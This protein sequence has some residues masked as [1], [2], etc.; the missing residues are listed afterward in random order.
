MEGVTTT[1]LLARSVN[2]GEADR[3]CTLLTEEL[4][5]VSALAKAARK[6]RKR[7]GGALSLFVVGRAVLKRPRRG[8]LLLLERFE[9]VE[10]LSGAV[11]SDVIK[12]AHGSYILEV[13]RELWPAEQ[14]EPEGFELVR[15]TLRALA[16]SPPAPP[17][18][19]CF[20]LG[21]LEVV[22]LAP[23]L[24][25]CVSCG[26]DDPDDGWFDVAHGGA[27]C[28]SCGPRGWPLAAD[29]RRMLLRL[30]TLAVGEAA[31]VIQPKAVARKTRDIMLATMRHHI[32]KDLQSLQF[33]VQM[34]GQ[35]PPSKS[36]E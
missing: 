35:R 26:L 11:S 15:E 25:R 13:A 9:A 20:E 32:G 23:V 30:G 7:Y 21:I 28:R 4:G 1:A 24:E 18:L 19:R 36:P 2:Y 5:K 6:S 34:K 29:A 16:A 27:V 33:L 17:L 14:P 22:G 10:D 3:I 12:V 31:A 8:E